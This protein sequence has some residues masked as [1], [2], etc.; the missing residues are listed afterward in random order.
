M[1]KTIIIWLSVLVITSMP[2]FSQDDHFEQV[3]KAM[4][5]SDARKLSSYFNV[6]ID[7]GLPGNDNSYSKSQAEMIMRDFFR[8]FPADSFTVTRQGVTD[9]ISHYVIGDYKTGSKSY[10]VYVYL[11]QVGERYLIHKIKFEDK[12]AISRPQHE[13]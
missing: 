3:I 9:A 7:L 12:P 6:N 11:R 13:N 2:V 8:K 4:Q 5:T 1:I 10:Q